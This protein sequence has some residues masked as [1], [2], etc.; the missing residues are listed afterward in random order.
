MSCGCRDAP[1]VAT[2]VAGSLQYTIH[3]PTACR[4]R[5]ENWEVGAEF[6]VLVEAEAEVD[7]EVFHSAEA[8]TDLRAERIYQSGVGSREGCRRGGDIHMEVV[9]SLAWD[10]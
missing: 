4:H 7:E 9:A 3:N 2:R 1:L 8:V 5:Q 6:D 10:R